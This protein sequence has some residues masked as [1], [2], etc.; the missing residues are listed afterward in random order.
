[1]KRDLFVGKH[2]CSLTSISIYNV[3]QSLLKYEDGV[4]G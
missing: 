4:Y 2:P 1:M 3:V